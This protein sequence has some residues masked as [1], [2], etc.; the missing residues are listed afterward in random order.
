MAG[1]NGQTGELPQFDYTDWS[2][3]KAKAIRFQ[4]KRIAYQESRVDNYEGDPDG[5]EA[6][7]AALE[8]A[9][10]AMYAMVCEHLISVPRGW[11]VSNA[12]EKL[13]WSKPESLDWIRQD[14]FEDLSAAALEARKPENVAGN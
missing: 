2:H 12:P 11:L 3:K 6:E 10:N 4:A 7:I 5:F 8:D 1:K 13:D 9:M 14:K